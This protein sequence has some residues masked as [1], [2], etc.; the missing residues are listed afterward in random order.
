MKRK[1]T[2]SITRSKTLRKTKNTLRSSNKIRSL[3]LAN[4]YNSYNSYNK[5]KIKNEILCNELEWIVDILGT[6]ELLQELIN[7]FGKDGGILI[8]KRRNL[9]KE[10]NNGLYFT[11]AHWISCSPDDDSYN[12]IKKNSYD[13]KHQISGTAHFCQ[14][15]ALMYYLNK[16]DVFKEEE[17]SKN[18]KHIIDFWI[19][20]FENDKEFLDK[21]LN[22]MKT[23]PKYKN[24]IVL[25]DER[26]KSYKYYKLNGDKKLKNYT[27]RQLKNF[28]LFIK[29][30]SKEFIMCKQD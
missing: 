25:S 15:F 2:R 1:S 14:S 16:D 27:W 22:E 5:S 17:Y 19:D 21:F 28:L 13:L 18:I 10:F 20:I 11:G 23:D 26:I 12:V 8:G 4:S 6:T 3:S 29:K 9:P 7:K 24:I 30:K